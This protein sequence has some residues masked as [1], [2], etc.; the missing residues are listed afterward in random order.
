MTRA[1]KKSYVNFV[2]RYYK[3][4]TGYIYKITNEETNKI[5]IGS[6]TTSLEQRFEEHK[7]CKDT[8]PLHTAMK[9]YKKWKIELVE[10]IEFIDYEELLIAETCY[11]MKYDTIAHGYNTKLAINYENIY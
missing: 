10:E 11:M 7:Q 2:A 1:T 8:S 5:Y 3:T 6:T 9:E 4:K